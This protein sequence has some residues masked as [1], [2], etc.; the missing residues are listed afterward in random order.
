EDKDRKMGR[1]CSPRLANMLGYFLPWFLVR[2]S[3]LAVAL[4]PL[5]G[6]QAQSLNLPPRPAAAPTGSQFINVITPMS[7]TERENWIYGQIVSGNVPDFLRTLVPVSVSATINGTNHSGTYYAA[8]D[9]LAIGTDADYFLEPMT[10]LLAQ[11]LCD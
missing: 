3:S 10:P 4:V 11:R 8:P 9:Y 2:S 1:T 7:L 5:A 6:L